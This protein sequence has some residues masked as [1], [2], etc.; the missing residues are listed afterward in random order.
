MTRE[1][2]IK[3][4]KGIMEVMTLDQAIRYT[5]EVAEEN[6]KDARFYSLSRPDK[7]RKEYSIKKANEY[8][9]IAKWLKEL[10]EFKL[11]E[12]DLK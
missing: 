10:K 4:E 3:G 12:D 5:E 6:E 9:Q 11:R 1:K 7:E 8:R 2:V